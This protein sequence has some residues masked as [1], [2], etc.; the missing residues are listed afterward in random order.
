MLA[1][2]W[3]VINALCLY[4]FGIVTGFEAEKYIAAAQQLLHSGMLQAKHYWFYS[5]E[6]FLIAFALK[7]YTFPFL[8][9]VVQLACNAVATVC[10]YKTALQLNGR[11]NIALWATAALLAMYYYQQYNAH[12]FTESLYFSFSIIFFY[13]LTS[14]KH[15]NRYHLA[16][17]AGLLLLCTR[18]VGLFYLPATG[19]FFIQKW[20]NRSAKWMFA[21]AAALMLLFVFLINRA[22]GSGG[23][24]DFLVPYA[25]E[26]VICEVPTIN[27]PHAIKVPVEKNSLQGLWYL[28]MH[29]GTLVRTLA[30]KRLLAFW[31]LLRPYYAVG[32][33]LF[34]A[35]YCYSMYLLILLGIK[36]WPKSKTPELAFMLCIILLTT[37]STMLSCDEWHNRFYFSILHL[38]ILLATFAFK[39]LQS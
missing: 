9:V 28:I 22:L 21:M 27:P 12:L 20:H 24:F 15:R 29:H 7:T 26:Q 19:L 31:G 39:P 38:L 34:L 23:G 5:T 17:I 4:R 36:N 1:G 33:N 32:H 8:P 6:I 37:I 30:F 2:L 18:P 16:A 11:K 10:F 3:V 35:V 14:T 13:L 25:Q